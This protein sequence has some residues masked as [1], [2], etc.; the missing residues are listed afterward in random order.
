L[1]W[2]RAAFIGAAALVVSAMLARVHPFGDAGLDARTSG[3]PQIMERAAVPQEVRD[4]LTA[5]CADCHSMQTRMPIYDRF[6][7]R[8][9]P[10]SW[11]MERDIVEGRKK[12]NLSL[13]ANYSAEQ[14]QT[15]AAKM[16]EEAKAHEMPLL[17]YRVIH[18]S[19]RL[20]DADEQVLTR[21]DHALQGGDTGSMAAGGSDAGRLGD[22]MRGKEVFAR[23]CT[24]CH[25]LTQD[26]E[27]PRLKG[28]YGRRSGTV[29]GFA[30]SPALKQAG[31]VWED[32]SLER[33]LTDPDALVAGNN[34]DFRVA[35]AQERKDLIAYLRQGSA[36]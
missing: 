8:F 10:V 30:Y 16:V 27:G 1:S 26:R 6:A 31:I 19:A 4:L 36:N 23:R 14:Q 2:C 7:S 25:A 17:Q 11:L 18:W 12:M 15:L 28:V 21:W 29:A 13:W 9:A 32:A 35:K 24:G 20:S 3:Q 22:S 33:W 5:K 34:M